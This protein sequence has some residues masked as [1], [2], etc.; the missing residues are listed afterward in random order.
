MEA[1]SRKQPSIYFI[2]YS[3]EQNPKYKNKRIV[4]IFKWHAYI[5]KRMKGTIQEG[6]VEEKNRKKTDVGR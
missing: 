3:T 4:N 5:D 1:V 2:D 6:K